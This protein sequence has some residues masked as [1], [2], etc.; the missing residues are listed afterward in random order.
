MAR[1][2]PL[3]PEAMNRAQRDVYDACVSGR[4]GR[5]PANVLAWLRS[6][7][8][9]S[10]AQRLGEFVRYDTALAPRLSELA[11]LVVARHWT[12]QY[13]WAVHRGE[14][15]KAGLAEEL[16]EAIAARKQPVFSD[17]KEQVV[18]DFAV[19]LLKTNTVPD[20]AY[21]AAVAAIGE[22]SVVE[23]VGV[24]GYYTLVSMTLN[25]FEIEPPDAA[26]R[27]A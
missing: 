5:A 22:Q 7:E 15:L 26:A 19:S 11:I 14:A 17:E 1:L 16:I 24:L 23:L 4:R 8:L 25:A 27:L 10:R 3:A 20:V 2:R 13:E 21:Q 12:S 18:Y 9:A 6:P